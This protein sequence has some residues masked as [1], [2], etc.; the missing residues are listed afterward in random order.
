MRSRFEGKIGVQGGDMVR[1]RCREATRHRC[2]GGSEAE[3]QEWGHVGGKESCIPASWKA[4]RSGKD[5]EEQP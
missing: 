1:V 4:Q 2:G 5:S 3:P